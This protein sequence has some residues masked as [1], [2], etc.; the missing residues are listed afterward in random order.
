MRLRHVIAAAATL[1]AVVASAGTAS[2]A[3]TSSGPEPWEPVQQEEWTR[4]AGVYCDFT[5][6]V[7]VIYDNEQTRV[8]S[9][10]PDGSVKQ[11]EYIGTLISD[12]V[13]V[14]TGARVRKN[15]SAQG[16]VDLR[17]DG[18][19]ERITGHGPFGAGFRAGDDYPRGYY[20]LTGYHSVV[21]RTDGTRYMEVDQGEEENICPLID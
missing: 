3:T 5:L 15:S 9:R 11:R 2:A 17:P 12:F 20:L 10:Y 19:W 8:L 14:E 13:N 16:V 18:S 21:F 6:H 7:D 1:T 4:P